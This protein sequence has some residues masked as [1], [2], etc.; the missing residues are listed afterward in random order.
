[1][2]P[3]LKW[4]RSGVS[5]LSDMTFLIMMN[6]VRIITYTFTNS[7]FCNNWT[8]WLV[9]PCLS[10]YSISCS[11]LLFHQLWIYSKPFSILFPST[12][13][14]CLFL[15]T[16]FRL[17]ITRCSGMCLAGWFLLRSPCWSSLR[18]RPSASC[19]SSTMWCRTCW[20]PWKASRPPSYASMRTYMWDIQ[21]R[22]Q[23]Y[24]H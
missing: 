16:S 7:A 6:S 15:R 9:I 3:K 8:Y 21:T 14:C 20:S 22:T 13:P 4:A 12:I 5:W 19:T 23:I 11:R 17:G 2:Q 24:T 1:M 10:S 18:E